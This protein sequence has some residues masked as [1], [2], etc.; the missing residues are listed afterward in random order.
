MHMTKGTNVEV[1]LLGDISRVAV[2]PQ[3]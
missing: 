1:A 3:V 2:K